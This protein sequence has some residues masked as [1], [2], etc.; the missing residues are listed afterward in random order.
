MGQGTGQLGT[1]SALHTSPHTDQPRD[2]DPRK[3]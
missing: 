3:R 2:E 1:E